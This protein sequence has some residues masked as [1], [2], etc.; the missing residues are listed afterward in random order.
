[1]AVGKVF[2][3]GFHKTGVT[4][5]R[6][7]FEVLGLDVCSREAGY[8][9]RYD[10]DKKIIM[11]ALRLAD[12]HEAFADS[13]WNY[14]GMYRVLDTVFRGS[15]FILTYRNFDTWVVSILR[16]TQQHGNTRSVDMRQTLRMEAK[17][18]ERKLL[19]IAHQRYVC[20]VRR[21][22][23]SR[24]G[25]FLEVNWERGD[26]WG[27]LCKFLDLP[28]PDATFPHM[29]RYDEETDSYVNNSP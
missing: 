17:P 18:E 20:N 25:R 19:H 24:K 22:F 8:A 23:S 16:W 7:C 3:I 15:K 29:L 6:K 12:E 21:F 5:L 27:K 1:M 9:V 4:T 10:V 11:P 28:I 14:R 13:P 2:G 26:G